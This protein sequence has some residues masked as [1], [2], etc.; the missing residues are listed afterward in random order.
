MSDTPRTTA[1]R[2]NMGSMLKPHYVVDEEVA[3]QLEREL[4][5]ALAAKEAALHAYECE[6]DNNV[7][8]ANGWDKE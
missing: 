1:A 7:A 3:A 8:M 5:A 6:Y 2:H 4:A